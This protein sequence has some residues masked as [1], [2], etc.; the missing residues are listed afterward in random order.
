MKL[1]FKA[2]IPSIGI[3]FEDPTVYFDMKAIAMLPEDLEKKLPA[4]C[5]F[6]GEDI[7]IYNPE[8][9][10]DV[11]IDNINI[12]SGDNWIWIDKGFDMYMSVDGAE[13]V[14]VEL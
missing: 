6:D 12:L 3:E 2:T 7:L 14:K 10:C 13:F 4:Y 9:D 5:I 1:K 11:A 8:E